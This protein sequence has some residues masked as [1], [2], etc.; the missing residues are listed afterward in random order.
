MAFWVC[1]GKT[2]NADG[3]YKC[4]AIVFL[5]WVVSIFCIFV[6]NDGEAAM[7]KNDMFLLINHK[8]NKV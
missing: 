6:I 1:A 5:F 4:F 8:M 2:R 7:K 3:N